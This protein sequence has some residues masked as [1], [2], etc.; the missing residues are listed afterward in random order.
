MSTTRKPSGPQ[1]V[2]PEDATTKPTLVDVTKGVDQE[3]SANQENSAD[4]EPESKL[5]I[6]KPNK[7]SLD[8]FKS[9]QAAVLANV[10][11][12]PTELK[13]HS[14]A[15]ARDFVRLHP[16][17]DEYWSPE[18]C[19][20]NVPIKGQKHDT[21]HLIDDN[22]ALQ[23]LPPGRILRFSPALA[24]KP[25][26]VLF[27]CKVPTR[28]LDNEWNRANTK[29]CEQARTLWTILTSRKE[30]GVETYKVDW[31]RDPDAFPP[32]KWPTLTLTEMIGAR[33]S[34]LS[35]EQEDHPGLLRLIG[36]RQS[37]S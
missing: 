9:K 25:Y 23:Y 24:C 15:E 7:F 28:N 35:I 12:L 33:F 37:I 13:I 3:K 6:P 5:V 21:L 32:P 22:L 11:T 2:I 8:K 36:A 14:I 27:L 19:F 16:D 34:G 20:V 18:L 1:L 10:E 26:D 4:Q 29:G 31:A 17:T 30:E